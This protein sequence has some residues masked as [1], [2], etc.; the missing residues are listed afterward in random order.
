[1]STIEKK[2]RKSKKVQEEPVIAEEPVVEE[3]IVVEETTES[4]VEDSVSFSEAMKA[5]V[6]EIGTLRTQIRTIETNLKSV[7]LLYKE[8]LKANKSNKRRKPKVEGGEPRARHGFV[9]PT[10]VSD[11]LASFLGEPVGSMIARPQVT[12]KISEYVK[13]NNCFCPM[14]SED[15]V[16]KTIIIPDAKLAK[17][18]GPP[19]FLYSKKKPELGK[20]YNYFN[21]QSY[22]KEQNH[23]IKAEQ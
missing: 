14:D 16:N 19:V 20:G 9:K 17:L 1:M 6:Q 5:L 3:P 13:A 22:L 18:L 12:K 11:A 2:S 21:L 7:R 23:F 8:E 15:K 10:L 4:S